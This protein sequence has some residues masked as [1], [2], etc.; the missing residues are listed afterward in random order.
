MQDSNLIDLA[1]WMGVVQ[2]DGYFKKVFYKKR[3]V[4]KY[5]ISLTVGQ[6]S[7]EMLLK[8]ARLSR[9]LFGIK[10]SIWVDKKRKSTSFTFGCKNLLDL[11]NYINID[12]SD[13][14]KPPKWIEND[15]SCFGAYLAGIIDG[16]GNVEIKRPKYP[17]CMIRIYSSEIQKELKA[18][19]LSNLKCGVCQYS[20]INHSIL[21]GRE[22]NGIEYIT[23]FYIS[24]KN[25]AFFNNY[26]L[27]NIAIKRKRDK[28]YK[29]I[30]GRCG[31]IELP[32]RGPQPRILTIKLTS[33][34][35]F[36]MQQ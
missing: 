36:S 29:Y 8:F 13:P 5:F 34:Y 6:C 32:S 10:G 12:F 27:R 19:L 22:I 9:K 30:L 4:Y 25:F 14:P 24:P 18:I 3:K 15:L 28:L 7:L 20:S 26:V 35:D 21:G 1:Y 23:Q 33:P 17:Q 2:T 11:F 16:D 31:R